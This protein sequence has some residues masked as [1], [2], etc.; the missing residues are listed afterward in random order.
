[1]LQNIGRLN[2]THI[3]WIYSIDINLS[4]K[5]PVHNYKMAVIKNENLKNYEGKTRVPE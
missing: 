3:I 5:K 2:E 1:M 4:T